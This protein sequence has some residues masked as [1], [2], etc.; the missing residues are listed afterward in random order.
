MSQR[1]EERIQRRSGWLIPAAVFIVTAALSALILLYYLV[2]FAISLA[3][4]GGR[5]LWFSYAASRGGNGKAPGQS[6]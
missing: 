6:S 3:I 5:E 1:G 2:P 4:L